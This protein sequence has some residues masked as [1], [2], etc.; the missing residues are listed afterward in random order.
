ML[1]L[2]V[3]L[4]VCVVWSPQRQEENRGVMWVLEVKSGFSG[5]AS[6][7]IPWATSPGQIFNFKHMIIENFKK[8]NM[9]KIIS[10]FF[11]LHQFYP[12]VKNKHMTKFRHFYN[13]FSMLILFLVSNAHDESLWSLHSLYTMKL[14]DWNLLLQ[15]VKDNLLQSIY[16]SSIQS[17]I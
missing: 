5:R 9:I 17:I 12:Y 13:S 15:Q 11:T 2:L 6:A 10:N 7:L 4:L 1:W 8:C 16:K 14:F 3:C